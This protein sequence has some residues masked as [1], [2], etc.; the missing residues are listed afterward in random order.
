VKS[1]R[2]VRD[3]SRGGCK[4]RQNYGP[5]IIKSSLDIDGMKITTMNGQPTKVA[6]MCLLLKAPP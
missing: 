2:T 4:I 3:V 1:K 5:I 6:D